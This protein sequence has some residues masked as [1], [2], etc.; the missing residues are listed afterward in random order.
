MLLNNLLHI[1]YVS[2]YYETKLINLFTEYFH[3][4]IFLETKFFAISQ[5]YFNVTVQPTP[6]FLKFFLSLPIKANHIYYVMLPD[7]LQDV[8]VS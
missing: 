8:S 4:I 1:Q 3:W 2:I 7:M 5:Y 6:T